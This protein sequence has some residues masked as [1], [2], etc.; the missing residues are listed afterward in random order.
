MQSWLTRLYDR[1]RARYVAGGLLLVVIEITFVLCPVIAIFACRYEG[2]S[3]GRYLIVVAVA[4]GVAAIVYS[5]VAVRLARPIRALLLWSNTL[6]DDYHEA[7]RTAAFEAPRR[8]GLWAIGMGAPFTPLVVAFMATPSHHTS[9]L[10][11]TELIIG[12][13]S[14]SLI[15][16]LNAWFAIDVLMRPV[17]A[18]FDGPKASFARTTL[19][20]RLALVVPSAIWASAFAVGYLTTTRAKA[21]AGHLLVVYA[22]AAGCTG[23]CALIVWP[24]FLGGVVTPIRELARATRLIA[25]GHT[26][27]RLAVASND[28]LGRL[29]Q[30]FNEMLDELQA[31]RVRIVTAADAARRRV[32]HDLHDGAQQRLVLLSLKAGMLEREL[33]PNALVAEIRRDIEL[34]LAELRDLAHGIYPAALESDGL[35]AALGTVAEHCPLP[36]TFNAD[37][38]GRYPRELEAAVYFCCLEALQ[39]AAKHAGDGA[40]AEMRLHQS[41]GSLLFEVA[42]DGTGFDPATITGSAGLQNIRDRIGALGGQLRIESSPGKGTRIMGSVAVRSR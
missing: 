7:A 12:A 32:E 27:T 11:W 26:D 28:E 16:G 8:A 19:L 36:T 35:A 3:V 24:L 29:A 40:R 30:S 23:F 21:G 42:D 5:I 14:A 15:A 18:S 33:G 31:S 10:D 22:I 39:N 34:A 4:W 25:T 1:H 6:A 37:G 9:P 20:G 38:A 17:R 2:L 13:L 41:D